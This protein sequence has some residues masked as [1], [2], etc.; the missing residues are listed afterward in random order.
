MKK[1]YALLVLAMMATSTFADYYIK[2]NWGGG[3]E[4]DWM[5]MTAEN[6]GADY[7]Y[8]GK[9]GG[10]GVNI[11]T[12]MN[13]ATAAWFPKDKITGSFNAGDEVKFTYNVA[14]KTVSAVVV[15]PGDPS[16]KTYFIKNNW[17]GATDWTWEQMTPNADKSVWTYT[18]EFGGTGVNI[19]SLASDDGAKWFELSNE[20]GKTYVFTYTVASENLTVKAE[21]EQGGGTTPGGNPGT[22]PGTNPGGDDEGYYYYKGNVNGDGGD[23]EYGDHEE[24]LFEGGQTTMW[25]TSFTSAAI[26]VIYQVDGK[27]GVQYMASQWDSPAVDHCTLSVNGGGNY[28]KWNVPVGTT[29]LYLYS[30]GDGTLE[31]SAKPIAGKTLVGGGKSEG[32]NQAVENVLV[33]ENVYKTIENGQIVIVRDGVRYNAQGAKF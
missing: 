19:N 22:N 16:A 28:Q 25:T 31:I 6:G 14:A 5:Q 32:D 4:W 12:E 20:A 15:T 2:N 18:G 7:T 23:F 8:T 13:D 29:N 33:N 3:A 27:E 10:S 30:N 26:F 24:M 11:N 1:I 9:F 21:G 17:G